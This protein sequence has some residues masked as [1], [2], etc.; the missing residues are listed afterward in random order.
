MHSPL[1]WWR[2]QAAAA[3]K[4]TWLGS[5]V[6]LVVRSDSET[7]ESTV[8][9]W[10]TLRSA[11]LTLLMATSTACSSAGC[12]AGMCTVTFWVP[13]APAGQ[14][15]VSKLLSGSVSVTPPA[16]I[17]MGSE[18]LQVTR[19]CMTCQLC[20]Q[21]PH[22]VPASCAT[23]SG[24]PPQAACWSRSASATHSQPHPQRL[25]HRALPSPLWAPPP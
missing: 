16:G 6:K 18:L 3:N 14:V 21:H 10:C 17:H 15:T 1:P 7:A 22:Q 2:L 20:Q 13:L 24:W 4:P 19:R 25:P 23:R 12:Q 8:V 5:I 9:L 11:S